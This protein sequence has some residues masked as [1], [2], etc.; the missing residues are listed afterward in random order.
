VNLIL[1]R[2]SPKRK[3]IHYYLMWYLY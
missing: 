2:Y 1:I 3:I